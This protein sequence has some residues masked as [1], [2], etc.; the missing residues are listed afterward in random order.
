[1]LCEL[2]MQRLLADHLYGNFV[3]FAS[4][5]YGSLPVQG[6]IDAAIAKECMLTMIPSGLFSE[7]R[8]IGESRAF[9]FAS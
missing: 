9:S 1:L 5:I 6:L 3:M 7:S 8:A 2:H 4:A